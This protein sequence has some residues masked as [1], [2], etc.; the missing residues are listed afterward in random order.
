MLQNSDLNQQNISNTVLEGL[1]DALL[2]RGQSDVAEASTRLIGSNSVLDSLGLVTLVIDLEQKIEEQYGVSVTL[3]DDRAM[4][5]KNSP[6][7]TVQSL[8][9]YIYSLTQEV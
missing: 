9:D 6:F 1:K 4:S 7:Q 5:Q 2:Q 8:A 3:T